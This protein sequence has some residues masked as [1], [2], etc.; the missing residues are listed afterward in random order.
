MR[1][2]VTYRHPQPALFDPDVR[3]PPLS[4]ATIAALECALGADRVLTPGEQVMAARAVESARFW[5]GR[6]TL[7]TSA[8]DC[9]ATLRAL[10]AESDALSELAGCDVTTRALVE[11][12]AFLHGQGMPD[13]LNQDGVRAAA[14]AALKHF[15]DAD[16]PPYTPLRMLAAAVV[17]LWR[18]FGGI[19]GFTVNPGK[20]F[21]SDGVKFAMALFDA[22]GE[23][24][25]PSTIAKLLREAWGK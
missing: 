7:R 20:D 3:F 18:A 1:G 16:G 21:A 14:R 19:G 17:G 24:R 11:A 2:K 5:R 22:A 4:A 23:P 15:P 13:L 10:A 25:S 9:R 6:A 12:A 8:A